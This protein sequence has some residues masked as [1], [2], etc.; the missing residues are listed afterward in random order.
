MKVIISHPTSNQNNRS[1]LTG[2]LEKEMLAEYHTS[3]ASFPGSILYQ[4]GD[5]AAFSDIRRRS[6]G[7]ELKSFTHSSPLHEIG[8]IMSGKF[9]FS[10]LT[11]HE[12][13][14]FCLDVVYKQLDKKV[15]RRLNKCKGRGID[16]VYAYED[17]ALHSFKAAKE[18]G[19]TCIYELPI[20]YWETGRKLLNEEAE[21]LPNW[22]ITLGGGIQDSAAKLERKTKELELADV[23]IGPGEFVMNSLPDWAKSKKLIVSPFGS[24]I[25]EKDQINNKRNA[26]KPLR[27]LFVGAMGQRKGLGDLFSAMKMLKNEN[28]ELVVLGS[29]LAPMEFYKNEFSDFIYEPCRS[30]EDVLKLMQTCDIFCLPSIVEGRALVM[31]EAMSQGLPLIIT[32]NT[33]GED[34]INE[35]ETGFLIP[36]RSPKAIAEKIM[37][38]VNNRSCVEEM[39]YKARCWA[40]NYTWKKYS[41]RIILEII[42]YQENAEKGYLKKIK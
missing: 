33:G 14:A 1:I 6:F 4:V 34:L 26:E 17:G 42:G 25:P 21:R 3:V 13:G 29:L 18:L 38:Y 5:I 20:A 19:I 39:G 10:R 2:L 15:S 16:A 41:Q 37:W 22:A 35:N 24:P 32:P 8:R 9:G 31:Q 30:H 7:P 28:V 12:Y 23:V 11:Q 27:I 40:A 36:I